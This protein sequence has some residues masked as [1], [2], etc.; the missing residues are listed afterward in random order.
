LPRISAALQPPATEVATPGDDV[1]V[2]AAIVQ[3]I[4]NG[5]DRM[6]DE[7]RAMHRQNERMADRQLQEK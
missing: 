3:S 2:T 4:D 5:R 6:L 7:L 1:N